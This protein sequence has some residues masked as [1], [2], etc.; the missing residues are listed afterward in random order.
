MNPQKLIENLITL[1]QYRRL[2]WVFV[3]RDL[4][5]RYRQ[6]K[7][8]ILWAVIQP[9]FMTV[10]FTVI[11]SKFLNV[12][13]DGAPYPVF[14]YIALTVWTFFSR[15]ITVG[16]TNLIGN[17]A[18]INKIYFPREV[19]PVSTVVSSLSDFGIA[20]VIAVVL[21][22]IYGVYPGWQIIFLPIILLVQIML[23]AAFA[24][25]SSST[26]VIFRDLQFAI[27]F[28][29][30]LL[31]YATPVIYSVR[32]LS[33]LFKTLMYLNPITGIIEGYRSILLYHEMPNWGY[34]SVSIIFAIIVFMFSYEVFKRIEKYLADVV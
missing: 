24:M 7:I 33:P 26:T 15:V 2:A 29:V 18:L 17:S 21:M 30:Q 12:S 6:T 27:P 34:L 23:A 9:L 4:R 14:S 25:F 22:V 19:F 13:S 16:A 3:W 20:S 8:G 10:I 11:F 5:S 1:Y 28:F 31:M 32:N